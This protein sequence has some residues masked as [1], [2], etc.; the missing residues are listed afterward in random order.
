M[1]QSK[2]GRTISL[3]DDLADVITDNLPAG[4]GNDSF[5]NSKDFDKMLDLLV[6]AVKGHV[7]SAVP[8][9]IS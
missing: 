6:D 3:R 1:K 7:E 8:S 4:D 5:C 9:I 2:Y